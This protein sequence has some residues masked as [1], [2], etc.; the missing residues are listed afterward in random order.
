M[1][2]SFSDSALVLNPNDNVAIAKYLL[3]PGASLL[4]PNNRT[5]TIRETIAPGHKFALRSIA[6]GDAV[7][8]Y[9]YSIGI[10]TQSIQP[11]DWVHTHNLTVGNL[12]QAYDYK[13]VE[14]HQLQAAQHYFQGFKRADGRVGTRNYIAVISTVNC[15]SH[16]AIEIARA[17]TPERL[18][19]YSN[20][21]GVIPLV[22]STGCSYNPND[23]SHTFLRR[24]LANIARN[25]NI[26]GYVFV[27]LGCEAN[28]IDGYCDA[29]LINPDQAIPI[30]GSGFVIQ[31]QGGF[32]K[33]VAAGIAAIEKILLQVNC[34]A[35]TPQPIS[36]LSL[37]LQCGGSDG[38]S[39]ITANPLVGCVVD[40]IVAQGGTAV[41]SETPEI[42]GAEHLLTHRV[43][44]ATVAQKLI[45]RFE[46]WTAQSKLLNFSMDNNPTPG[47]KRGGLTTIFEK[48]LGAAAKGGSTPLTDVY[49]YAELVTSNGLVFMDTPGYDPV[50]ATGQLAGGCNLILFTTGR[51]SVFASNVAPCVKIASHS[52]LFD[53]MSDDMDFN[54]G[55]I[56]D[57]V[58]MPVA[59]D[60]LLDLVI[61]VASGERT[62]SE[63]YGL[64]ESEFVPWQPGI[65]I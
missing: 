17:F 56:I 29:A 59:A 15:S 1:Q 35:R 22:H 11:G 53:R 13:I 60:A 54:A 61:R 36:A 39:G 33:T 57:G 21:D 19:P 55:Q 6:Q 51:G 65:V 42:F 26:G 27:G 48:S 23:L 40:K 10:A 14:P 49:E 25:P 45:Q 30:G 20:I 32:R 7:L 5:L 46:W 12:N 58:S 28:P 2:R 62:K 24:T 18:A 37:A 3:D 63:N 16:A 41:L 9:G 52:A 8:R 47:N 50:S 34:V 38:W 31:D 4:L 44:N 43:F 64:P